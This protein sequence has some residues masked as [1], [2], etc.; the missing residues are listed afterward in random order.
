MSLA[1]EMNHP[2]GLAVT[3][4]GGDRK[5]RTHGEV[6]EPRPGARRG[7]GWAR[8]LLREINLESTISI[9]EHSYLISFLCNSSWCPRIQPNSLHPTEVALPSGSLGGPC[10][11]TPLA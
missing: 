10:G 1:L 2:N 5:E 6:L 8:A 7:E 3:T 9:S 4:A 11:I